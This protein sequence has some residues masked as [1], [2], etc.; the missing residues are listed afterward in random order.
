MN[1]INEQYIYVTHNFGEFFIKIIVKGDVELE[2]S[3]IESIIKHRDIDLNDV[4]W[5]HSYNNPE[6]ETVI[7]NYPFV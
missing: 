7:I 4:T 3:D 5:V 2:V 1:S 6:Q